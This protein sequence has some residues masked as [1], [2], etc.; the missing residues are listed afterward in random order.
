MLSDVIESSPSIC[1]NCRSSGVA[2]ADAIVSGFAPGSEAMRCLRRSRRY[3]IDARRLALLP[4]H[5]I[6]L[7]TTDGTPPVWAT[8]GSLGRRQESGLAVDA[9]RRARRVVVV[10]ELAW[11]ESVWRAY[12]S[13]HAIARAWIHQARR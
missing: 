4:D 7:R 3:G 12:A 2:T 11:A 10:P 1:E 9:L 5:A 8:G 13:Q 6:V